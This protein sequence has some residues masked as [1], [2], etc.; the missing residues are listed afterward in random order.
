MIKKLKSSIGLRV[1]VI[2]IFVNFVLCIIKFIAGIIG[3]SGAMISDAVHSASDVLST[4]IVIIGVNMS[5]KEDDSDH[6]Y[7]HERLECIAAIFLSAVLFF[8]G[9]AIG[10]NGIN[11]IYTGEYNNLSLP[12]SIALIAAIVSIITKEWMYHYTKSAAKKIN[13][14]A[15]LADAWHHRSDALSSVGSLIGIGGAMMGYPI[16]DSIAMTV[17]SVLVIKASYEIAVDAVDKLVDKAV[18]EETLIKIQEIAYKTEGVLGVD[19]VK[20]RIFGNKCYVDVEICCDKDIS[21]YKA[22]GIAEKVHDTIEENIPLVKH[23]MVHVNPF[24]SGE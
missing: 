18:D 12:T 7:G 15:M 16:L 4:F 5:E 17:I 1:S 19:L 22:H 20:T 6:Q 9:G 8:T 24:L 14:G 10:I 21:L 23:C 13:S 3:N 11:N 2:T